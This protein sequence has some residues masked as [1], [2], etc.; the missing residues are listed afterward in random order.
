MNVLISR[1]QVIARLRQA[2]YTF[3]RQADRVELWRQRGTG[4]RVSITRRDMLTEDEVRIVLSQAGLTEQE[5]NQ[6]LRECVK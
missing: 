4:R 3:Q 2:N 6:F 1:D 5:T